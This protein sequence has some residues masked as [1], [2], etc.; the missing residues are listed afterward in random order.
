MGVHVR[1]K[2][3][4]AAVAAVASAS[5]LAACGGGDGGSEGSGGGEGDLSGQQLV[6]VNYGGSSLDAAQKGWLD[7]FSEETGVKFATDS[8]SDPA[9]VKA[10]VDSGNT[11]WDVIDLGGA[12]GLSMC[13]TLLEKRPSD[14]DIGEID[15]Q[16]V[17]DDCGVPIFVASM[18]IV[19]NKELYGDNPPTKASDFLDVEKFPGKRVFLNYPEGLVEPLL[20][21]AGVTNDEMYPIDWSKVQDIADKL[22]DEMTPQDTV[23]AQT[24]SLE[25][26][27]YGMCVC[28]AGSMDIASKNGAEIGVIWEKVF[29]SWDNLYAVKGSKAPD[30]QWAFLQYVAT[31]DGQAPFF[32]YSPYISP[33]KEKPEVPEEFAQ[34]LPQDHADEVKEE[35]FYD[36][37]YWADKLESD[38]GKWA[39][40]MSG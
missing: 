18:P 8:P 30:A 12:T 37:Q 5:M 4:L 35:V 16:Y 21:T 13:G 20:M 26:G 17:G 40:I 29:Y 23:T 28:F 2:K 39:E 25:S 24:Q 11:T 34:W 38:Y 31:A 33:M 1:N 6:F 22:G 10:M 36:P 27:D 9:K 3:G 19:Y 7:P 15:P 32:K 14:F